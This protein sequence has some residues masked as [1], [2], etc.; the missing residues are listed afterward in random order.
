LRAGALL[1]RI[2]KEVYLPTV[3]PRTTYTRS[4]TPVFRKRS[5]VLKRTLRFFG[6]VAVLRE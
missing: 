2:L 6:E 1:R 5:R 3:L 4:T